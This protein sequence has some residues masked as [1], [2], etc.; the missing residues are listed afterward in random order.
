MKR[1]GANPATIGKY[2]NMLIELKIEIES[3]PRTKRS[4]EILEKHR[5][6]HQVLSMLKRTG[7]IT[8]TKKHGFSWS[9][10]H[11][12]IKMVIDIT[13]MIHQYKVELKE[14][15]KQ[16]DLFKKRKRSSYIKADQKTDR[17]PVDDEQRITISSGETIIEIEK[18]TLKEINKEDLNKWHESYK[19]KIGE[20]SGI[21]IKQPLP[22]T[23][24][25]SEYINHEMT[26]KPSLNWFQK[27]IKYIFKIK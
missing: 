9:G 25:V 21:P 19:E 4:T 18:K 6:G 5:C 3:N 12:T 23:S 15:K 10:Q 16:T 11:P 1:R 20:P 8:Y 13:E 17:I 27:L 22:D 14:R 24:M 2:M 7:I 26:E